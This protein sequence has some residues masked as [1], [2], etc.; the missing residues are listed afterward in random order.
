[1]LWLTFEAS[2]FVGRLHPRTGAVRL[3]P[4]PTSRSLPYGIVVTS[5]GIPFYCE[6]GSNKLASIDPETMVIT[7][8]RLPD[9]ARPRRL[10]IA[11]GDRIYY[12][13]Y[14]RGYLGRFDPATGKVD[15]W[16]SPGGPDSKP[17]G[18][19]TTPDGAVWYSESGVTPNTI[20]R[21]EP[22]ISAFSRW[23]IPSGGGVVRNMVSTPAGDLYIACSG[24]NKVGIVRAER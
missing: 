9:G 21:F 3:M 19:T 7:E 8:H 11:Q 6:F 4:S 15:E 10:T 14:A 22:A 2:N 17:Y 20:V 5:R 13:D 18:I 24:V 12:S 1:M 16:A 23:P